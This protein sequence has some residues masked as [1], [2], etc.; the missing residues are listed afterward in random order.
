MQIVVTILLWI[1]DDAFFQTAL[2]PEIYLLLMLFP[3]L[4]ATIRR[5]HDTRKECCILTAML[6]FC[7]LM[8]Y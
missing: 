3:I 6:C 7:L 8:K 1:I 4:D 2:L 5:L